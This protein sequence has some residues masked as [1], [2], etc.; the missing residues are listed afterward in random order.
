[1]ADPKKGH[2]RGLQ[3][4][5][6]SVRAT[7]R[8]GGALAVVAASG[9]MNEDGSWAGSSPDRWEGPKERPDS[10]STDWRSRAELVVEDA[11]G[12]RRRRRP[13]MGGPGCQSRPT[14]GL[15]R[16][17]ERRTALTLASAGA[18]RTRRGS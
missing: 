16:A 18:R 4:P 14:T 10:R 6:M 11:V 12:A 1:M 8:V 2:G 13:I 3:C 17:H 15:G 5:G 9:W 7:T